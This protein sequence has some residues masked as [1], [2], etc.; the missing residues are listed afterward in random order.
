MTEKQFANLTVKLWRAAQRFRRLLKFYKP[1]RATG[2]ASGLPYLVFK[3]GKQFDA[4]CKACDA[5][6]NARLDLY[7]AADVLGKRQLST[8]HP[9]KILAA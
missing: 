8:A 1:Q 9:D 4:I 6:N 3:D 7:N 2:K 5:L